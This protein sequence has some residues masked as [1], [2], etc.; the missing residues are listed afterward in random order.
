MNSVLQC[1]KTDPITLSHYSF[2]LT[3]LE[4]PRRRP[5]CIMFFILIVCV[6]FFFNYFSFHFKYFSNKNIILKQQ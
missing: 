6:L 2:I 5:F 4:F 3:Y 1:H